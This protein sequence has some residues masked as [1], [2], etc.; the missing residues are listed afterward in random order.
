LHIQCTTRY[1]TCACTHIQAMYHQT[2][3]VHTQTMYPPDTARTHTHTQTMYHQTLCMARLCSTGHCARTQT[4]TKYCM[5]TNYE[6]SRHQRPYINI[7]VLWNEINMVV[8]MRVLMHVS[9]VGRT[10]SGKLRSCVSTVSFPLYSLR[11]VHCAN[12]KHIH[13]YLLEYQQLYFLA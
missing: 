3:C 11:V 12:P 4:T 13:P 2:L 8:Q 10:L 5:Q 6:L 9:I 1:C 7:F